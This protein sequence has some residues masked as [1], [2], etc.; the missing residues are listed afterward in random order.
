MLPPPSPPPPLLSQMPTRQLLSRRSFIKCRRRPGTL[1]LPSSCPASP[2]PPLR[3]HM[4]PHQL[5]SPVQCLEIHMLN[6]VS[7]RTRVTNG[8]M[9]S[10]L[11][12]LLSLLHLHPP[13]LALSF[14][15]NNPH[16]LSS[17]S[18]SHKCSS[19]FST[20]IPLPLHQLQHIIQHNRISSILGAAT[21]S[22]S[23]FSPNSI[24]LLL[25]INQARQKELTTTGTGITML[26]YKL[27][28]ALQCM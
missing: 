15:T 14:C 26:V 10:M 23:I 16:R 7:Y 13:M 8:G 9:L 28:A 1:A 2:P 3:S 22:T 20:N 24:H 18:S 19:S 25:C 11:H 12:P 4:R 6:P 5:L 21:S 17:S 27:S